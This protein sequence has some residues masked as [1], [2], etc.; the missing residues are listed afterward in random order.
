MNFPTKTDYELFVHE[1]SGSINPKICFYLYGSFTRPDDFVPGRSDLDGGFILDTEF[2]TPLEAVEPLSKGLAYWLNVTERRA[3]LSHSEP[4]IRTNFNLMDRGINRDGRFL[5]Y[6][7]TYTDYL[8]TNARV[9]AGPNF[10][11]EMNGL[12]Y[13]RESLRSAAYNLRKVRNGLLTYFSDLERNPDKARRGVQSSINVLW[14]MPKKLLE[15]MGKE[16]EFKEGAFFET[17]KAIF[18]DYNKDIYGRVIDLRSNPHRFFG[19][20][21]YTDE[22][23]LLSLDCLNATERMI[24]GYTRRLPFATKFEVN[25]IKD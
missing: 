11:Q 6:D 18:P 16:L 4:G 13:K 21:D 5:A 20:L 1:L 24:E 19:V 10:V 22:A 2:V 17:F 15:T 3:R 8:K 25:P 9:V 23:F 14:G 7:N 12:N